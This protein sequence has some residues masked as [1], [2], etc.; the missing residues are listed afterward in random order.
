M[1]FLV[2]LKIII[3][4]CYSFFFNYQGFFPKNWFQVKG[5][6]HNTVFTKDFSQQGNFVSQY[7]D[8]IAPT[9]YD[10]LNTTSQVERID[11]RLIDNESQNANGYVS[12]YPFH[13]VWWPNPIPYI[14]VTPWHKTLAIH[15]LRHV[16]QF[17]FI[18]FNFLSI[19]TMPFWFLEGDAV[20]AETIYSS[21]GRGRVPFFDRYLRTQLLSM[22]EDEF[23]KKYNYYRFYFGSDE[24][25][26]KNFN[27]YN[28]GY[29]LVSYVYVHQPF[30]NQY[31]VV[32]KDKEISTWKKIIHEGYLVNSPAIFEILFYR[33][34]NGDSSPLVF[35]FHDI[36]KKYTGNSSSQLY[37]KTMLLRNKQ[38]REQHRKIFLE[39][40]NLIN[41]SSNS[42][43]IFSQQK[44]F[45]IT[46]NQ[47][48]Y[49][50][51]LNVSTRK[52][53]YFLQAEHRGNEAFLYQKNVNKKIQKIM[54]LPISIVS[55][56]SIGFDNFSIGDNKI[57]FLKSVADIRYAGAGKNTIV[58]YNK[59]T[60]QQSEIFS[61]INAKGIAITSD[62]KKIAIIFY[63]AKYHLRLALYSLQ[64]FKKIEEVDLGMATAAYDFSWNEKNSK[65][66]FVKINQHP[67]KHSIC[68]FDFSKKKF[69]EYLISQSKDIVRQPFIDG[70][71]LFYVSSYNG[72]DNLYVFNLST[73]KRYQVT[74]RPFSATRPKIVSEIIIK[75]TT[76]IASENKKKKIYFNDYSVFGER[77]SYFLKEKK[78]WLPIEKTKRYHLK[79]PEK[80]ITNSK[81]KT[82]DESQFSPV[83]S[84]QKITPYYN[85]FEILSAFPNGDI[86]IILNSPFLKINF[87]ELKL[88]IKDSLQSIESYF[89]AGYNYTRNTYFLD[90]VSRLA[91]LFPIFNFRFFYQSKSLDTN[92]SNFFSFL[93]FNEDSNS[94]LF[95]SFGVK[96]P[97]SFR[98]NFKTIS[99]TFYT[100][101]YSQI[102]LENLT[103]ENFTSHFYYSFLFRHFSSVGF[104]LS[105]G[106]VHK[107]SDSKIFDA[108]KN[109]IIAYLY[110]NLIFFKS[111]KNIFNAYLRGAFYYY[112]DKLETVSINNHWQIKNSGIQLRNSKIYNSGI[113]AKNIFNLNGEVTFPLIHWDSILLETIYFRS[114][115]LQFGSDF[116]FANFF[117]HPLND[118]QGGNITFTTYQGFSIY[119]LT[120][121]FNFG[122]SYSYDLFH[123]KSNYSLFVNLVWLNLSVLL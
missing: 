61:K 27:F 87:L 82:F 29:H 56:K 88:D 25:N 68:S 26:Y 66:F 116:L 65:I 110:N 111:W 5:Q 78:K 10:D 92:N 39:P 37:N 72:I 94:Y 34:I 106:Y 4:Y 123:Q 28:I 105:Q 96:I 80:I 44:I 91:N 30:I 9:I 59:K 79:I 104:S 107:I 7:I 46:T 31:S 54:T 41:S 84:N 113:V 36:L 16:A 35:F 6:Y 93:N 18:F 73:K 114:T 89:S 95:P 15:E 43:S 97:L 101:M 115:Y 120:L 55:S 85:S 45:K 23:L 100:Q 8:F 17:N 103:Q 13:S 12:I 2:F 98:D 53:I 70:N 52:S 22:S 24:N 14:T 63:D 40:N 57:A 62:D 108:D 51:Y 121:K 117:N 49:T 20:V 69:Q 48:R 83:I 71:D 86:A 109:S 99:V 118:Y 119:P 42:S 19:P 47:K 77:V 50:T 58:L 81:I 74:A 11:I 3:F 102:Q 1:R 33:I 60:K 76:K 122:S 64:N 112:L 32:E 75:T 90:F 21:F 67:S 38:W